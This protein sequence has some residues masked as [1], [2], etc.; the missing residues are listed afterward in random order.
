MMVNPENYPSPAALT[1]A[2]RNMR[3]VEPALKS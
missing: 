1:N 3:A 2:A